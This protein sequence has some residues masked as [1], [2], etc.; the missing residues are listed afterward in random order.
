MLTSP[1]PPPIPFPHHHF[2]SLLPRACA[3][4][5]YESASRFKVG[6]GGCL[7]VMRCGTIYPFLLRHFTYSLYYGTTSGRSFLFLFS[8]PPII[9]S[10]AAS[11]FGVVTCRLCKKRFVCMERMIFVCCRCRLPIIEKMPCVCECAMKVASEGCIEYGRYRI[12]SVV[13]HLLL[14][15]A[16][17][18]DCW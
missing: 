6:G 11:I 4:R 8:C 13:A 15:N 12:T 9:V 2:D 1:S 14:T 16:L 3:R 7:V 5:L 17:R 18:A 10:T